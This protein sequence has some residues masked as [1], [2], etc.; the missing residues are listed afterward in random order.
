MIRSPS[1]F[2]IVIVCYVVFGAIYAH[3]EATKADK[4]DKAIGYALEAIRL[5]MQAGMFC[6]VEKYENVIAVLEAKREER[7]I[8][9][10]A[11]ERAVKWIKVFRDTHVGHQMR[12]GQNSWDQQWID[13]YNFIISILEE[14]AR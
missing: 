13:N 5:D 8:P 9:T 1:V 11:Y 3:I 6:T 2:G 10:E 7:M 4:Y 14:D 12:K